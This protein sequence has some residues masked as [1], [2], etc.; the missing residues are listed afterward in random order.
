[1]IEKLV[2]FFLFFMDSSKKELFAQWLRLH[3]GAVHENPIFGNR[4]GAKEITEKY[5]T[6]LKGIYLPV[7]ILLIHSHNM[8]KEAENLIKVDLKAQAIPAQ[9]QVFF[10][11]PGSNYTMYSLFAENQAIVADFLGLEFSR[12]K[13]LSEQENVVAQLHRARKLRAYMRLHEETEPSRNIQDYASYVSDRSIAQLQRILTGYFEQAKKGD[14]VVVPP[15]AFAQ[16]ALIGELLDDP[17]DFITLTFAKLYGDERLYGRRVRWLGRI[18]KGKLSPYML[19]LGSKPNA[20]VLVPKNER[21]AIYREAYGSYIL[22]GEYRVRFDVDDPEYTTTDDLYIQAFLSFVAANSRRIEKQEDLLPIHQAAFEQL[23]DYALELQSNINSPGFLNL[24][25]SKVSPLVAAALFSLAVTVGPE[26]VEAANNGLIT[27]GNS[28]DA[29][30]PC[31]VAIA[32]EVVE[33]LRLLGVERWAQA[34]DIARQVQDS[35][36]LSGQAE[37]VIQND[38]G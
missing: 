3:R 18:P 28:L 36:G 17:G 24:L 4:R 30:D 20:F 26:A 15:R 13:V 25:S 21:A 38:D 23:G 22:P 16:D 29:G 7:C 34:C 2:G 14:L 35:T 32:V 9:N 37:V 27:I 5:R 10:V 6:T 11:R 12:G 1:M 31:T 33:H 19:D 8:R